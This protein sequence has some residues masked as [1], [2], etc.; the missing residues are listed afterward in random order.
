MSTKYTK[1]LKWRHAY[2]YWQKLRPHFEVWTVFQW[3]SNRLQK[4]VAIFRGRQLAGTVW[5]T[6][7]FSRVY[8]SEIGSYCINQVHTMIHYE[9]LKQPHFYSSIIGDYGSRHFLAICY[10]TSTYLLFRISS[11]FLVHIYYATYFLLY[12]KE[13]VQEKK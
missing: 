13:S 8:F 6:F 2:Y 10:A 11:P 7:P 9:I 12:T 5:V 4:N 3:G 1:I